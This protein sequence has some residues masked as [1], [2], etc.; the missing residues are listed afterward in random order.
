MKKNR[1]QFIR[2]C[3][4]GASKPMSIEAAKKLNVKTLRDFKENASS[5]F[6]LVVK[7]VSEGHSLSSIERLLALNPRVIR[8]LVLRYPKLGE[9]VRQAKE[10]KLDEQRMSEMPID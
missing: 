9:V 10:N 2:N 8:N 5:L 3:L 6:P 7:L 1:E 4:R